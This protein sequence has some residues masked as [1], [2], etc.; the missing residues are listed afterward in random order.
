MFPRKD[1]RVPKLRF[2]D[3][4]G[5]WAQRKLGKYLLTVVEQQSKGTLLKMES[6]RLFLLEV[7]ELIVNMLIKVLELYQMR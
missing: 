5:E 6:I 4:E 1:E 2:A 7:M 3:F